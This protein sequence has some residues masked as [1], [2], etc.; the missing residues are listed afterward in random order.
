MK[1]LLHSLLSVTDNDIRAAACRYKTDRPDVA[2]DIKRAA[3]SVV[4]RAASRYDV[5]KPPVLV[6]AVAPSF[7][8]TGTVPRFCT[9]K[10][11]GELVTMSSS[12]VSH[13]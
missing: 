4:G 11:C 6:V 3:G 1:K 8:Y 7:T 12:L 13:T 5:A 10:W 2:A 9:V